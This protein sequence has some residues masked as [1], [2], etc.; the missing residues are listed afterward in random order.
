MSGLESDENNIGTPMDD[1][2]FHRGDGN[3][4][5]PRKKS[6]EYESDPPDYF[7]VQNLNLWHV[8]GNLSRPIASFWYQ[9]ILLLIVAVPA[10]LMYSWIL[11]NFILPFPAALGFKTLTVTY[12]GLFFSIMDVAT[13]PACERFV[14]QYAEI[15]PRK[16]LKYAQFFIYFQMFTGLA[17]V[18]VVAVLYDLYCLH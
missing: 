10:I 7:D 13:G 1:V 2:G 5:K 12:F 17:Q 14:A 4:G 8:A 9:F 16:S 18:T 11:P 3:S 15:D 6:S